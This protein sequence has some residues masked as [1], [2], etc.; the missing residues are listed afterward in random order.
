MAGNLAA[1]MPKSETIATNMPLIKQL[2]KRPVDAQAE[3]E[4]MLENPA[5]AWYS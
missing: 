2:A 3:V 4:D 1:S 5:V